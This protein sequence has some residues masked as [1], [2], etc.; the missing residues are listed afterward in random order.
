MLNSFLP[1]KD[2]GRVAVR[3]VLINN[4]AIANLI[5]EDKLDQIISTLQTSSSE[6]M[7]T[8]NQSIDQLLAKGVIDEKVAANRKRDLETKSAYY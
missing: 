1:T 3:E 7:I 2:G 6:G 5:R 8:M 4:S